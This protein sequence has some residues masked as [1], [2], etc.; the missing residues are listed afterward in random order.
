MRVH[1]HACAAQ[2]ALMLRRSGGVALVLLRNP[3]ARPT[4][5]PDMY[6]MG[7]ME[8]AQHSVWDG[9]AEQ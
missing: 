2:T 6:Y 8:R 4:P 7:A 3:G 1:H 9:E 5:R